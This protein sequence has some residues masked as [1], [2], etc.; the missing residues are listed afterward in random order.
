M[1]K[2]KIGCTWNCYGIMVIEADSE[3]EAIRI[4]EDKPLPEGTYI[5]DSFEVDYGFIIEV[6]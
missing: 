5:D 3:D 2:Y 4:A 6:D 1:P